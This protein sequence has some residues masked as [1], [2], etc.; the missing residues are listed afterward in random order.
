MIFGA[1]PYGNIITDG[2]VLNL[3]AT[4]PA[5][6]PGTGTTWYDRS[7]YNN[8]GTLTNG[9]TYL[10]ERGRGSI[11]MDGTNDYVIVPNINRA[12]F[13]T[14][15]KATISITFKLLTYVD[16]V[17]IFQI[18]DTLSNTQPWILLRTNGTNTVSWYLDTGYRINQTVIPQVYYT[19]TLTYDGATWSA[20]SNGVASG[21]YAGSI[22]IFP[23]SYFYIGNGYNGYSNIQ[24][25]TVQAY[26][27]ALS[28]QEVLQNY[29]ALKSRFV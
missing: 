3:D 20:Y 12:L 8:N 26:T 7:G 13:V 27:R 14:N 23:G 21:S 9:P 29:N 24:V 22:G 19:L 16:I 28:S 5:S 17:G 4:N 2:L 11:I 10:Q 6:Y 25:S 1:K 15:N 18:A